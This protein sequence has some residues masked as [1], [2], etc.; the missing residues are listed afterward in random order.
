MFSLFADQAIL[1]EAIYDQ[2][3]DFGAEKDRQLLRLDMRGGI[4]HYKRL[5]STMI[6]KPTKVIA[7]EGDN[8]SELPILR[9]CLLFSDVKAAVMI[10]KLARLTEDINFTDY[11]GCLEDFELMIDR[12]PAQQYK[13]ILQ[14]LGSNFQ[15]HSIK[16]ALFERT[17]ANQ[18]KTF[19]QDS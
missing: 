13:Y 1:Y 10:Y 9:Q 14:K 12:L 19:I 2:V 11:I 4:E 5:I 6:L 3:I 15:T 7:T 17:K 16:D 18:Q 8:L